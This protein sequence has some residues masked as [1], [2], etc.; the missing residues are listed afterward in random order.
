MNKAVVFCM[1]IVKVARVKVKTKAF[2]KSLQS[3]R[4]VNWF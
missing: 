1:H 3:Q 2:S 4:S